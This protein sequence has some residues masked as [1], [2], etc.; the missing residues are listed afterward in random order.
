MPKN[1]RALFPLENLKS[2]PSEALIFKAFLFAAPIL[3]NHPFES[4]LPLLPGCALT[5]V[6]L[7][8]SIFSSNLPLHF[9]PIPPFFDLI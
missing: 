1:L 4:G 6:F 3:I 7:V 8:P 5:T 9:K 2:A